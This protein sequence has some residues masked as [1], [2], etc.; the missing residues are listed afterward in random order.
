MDLAPLR[1]QGADAL[2]GCLCGPLSGL[3]QEVLERGGLKVPADAACWKS[4]RRVGEGLLDR[5]EIGAIRRQKEEPRSGSADCS[6]DG[7]AFVTSEIAANDDLTLLQCWDEELFDI[8][9]ER[10]AVD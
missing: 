7:L 9:S 2:R 4:R 3:S 5:V 10:V 8:E 6:P 1:S